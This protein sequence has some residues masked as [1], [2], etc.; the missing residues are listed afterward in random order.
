MFV[1]L[2][3]FIAVAVLFLLSQGFYSL[4]YSL[5]I[6]YIDL[7]KIIDE[8]DAAKEAKAKLQEEYDKRQGELK[9]MQDDIIKLQNE[10]AQ[11][12]KFMSQEE[13]EKKRAQLQEKQ[14][15]FMNKLKEA[16]A[17]IQ[18]LDSKLTQSV[19]QELRKLVQKIAE[20]EG[21]DLVLEKSQILYVKDADDI[22]YRVIDEFNRMWR[23]AKETGNRKGKGDEK[24]RKERK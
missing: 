15:E 14:I 13:I 22:T 11:K 6:A 1:K 17:Q 18:L 8:T 12:T 16:E 21:Y 9:K 5:K 10:M 3:A 2:F 19:M 4:A 20:T 23:K 24:D 7:A